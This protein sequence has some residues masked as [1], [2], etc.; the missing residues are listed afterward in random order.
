[1][2]KYTR[3]ALCGALLAVLLYPVFAQAATRVQNAVKAAPNSHNATMP[4][5]LRGDAWTFGQSLDRNDVIWKK[6]INAN[7]VKARATGYKAKVSKQAADTR[8]SIDNAIG[9]NKH[10]PGGVSV[11]SQKSSWKAAPEEKFMRPDEEMPREGR[12]VV[13]AFADVAPSENLDI[14]IGPE[15][16]LKDESSRE[17]IANSTQP[18]T[19]L[20][21]GM[22]FKLDF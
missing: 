1:M 19:V 3:L 15:L 6:G 11:E 18:D 7:A 17:Q 9:R 21:L 12:H 16:I 10:F 8:K 13:R 2:F 4:K 5:G 22:N 20:G 14:N